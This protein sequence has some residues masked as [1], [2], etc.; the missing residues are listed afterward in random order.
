M[1]NWLVRGLLWCVALVAA[2][3][4]TLATTTS[5]GP[6]VAIPNWVPFGALALLFLGGSVL[7]RGLLDRAE[8]L[9]GAEV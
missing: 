6:V 3:G 9:D 1:K 5:S 2:F 7:R 8:A 4:F